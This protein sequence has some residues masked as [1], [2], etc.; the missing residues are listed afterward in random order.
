VEGPSAS[1]AASALA[2][3][4][5]LVVKGRAPKTGYSREQF[6]E[7]WYDADHN[8]CDT[9][10]DIL[11][12]D[13]TNVQRRAGS[14]CVV[15][16]GVLH[17]PYTGRDVTFAKENASAVQIDHVV[18]LSDSWQKG[19]Q[20]WDRSKRVALANDF[21]NLL[22]VDGPTNGAKGDGDAATW[23]PPNKP[24]RCAYVAR[25]V[26]VK[27]KYALWVTAAERDAMRRVLS[28][29]P[30][31]ALPPDSGA[32]TAVPGVAPAVSSSPAGGPAAV[33]PSGGAATYYRTCADARAAG[34][35][36]IRAGTPLYE[37]N[38]HLDRDGDGVAC[39]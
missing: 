13:L 25:Q 2:A 38:R 6:G 15:I 31:Q 23:L 39:E 30:D 12:R 24:Y 1:P 27:V 19:S 21:L 33:P 11:A 17:D 4:D 8:G 36:P 10:N 14:D 22:A 32:P 26:A 16:A 35:T 28:A 18:A 5:S 7:A 34:V 9:R 37:E 29:C 3:I 20:Y